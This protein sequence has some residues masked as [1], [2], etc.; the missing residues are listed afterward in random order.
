[1]ITFATVER[2]DNNQLESFYSANDLKMKQQQHTRTRKIIRIHH[3]MVNIQM[4]YQFHIM[5]VRCIHH[6]IISI[7]QIQ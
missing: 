4:F 5:Y 2:L 1:M 6:F 3:K 7:P